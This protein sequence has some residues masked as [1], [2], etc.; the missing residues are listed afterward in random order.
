MDFAHCHCCGWTCFGIFVVLYAMITYCQRMPKKHFTKEKPTNVLITGGVQG[1][2]KLLAQKFAA[3]SPAGSVNLI[4]CD[5]REDLA[6]DLLEDVKK[7]SGDLKFANIHFYKANLA[8]QKDVEAFWAK[9]TSE[10]GEIHILVN[11][12]ARCIGKRVDE[13]SISQ[14]KLTMDINFHSYVHLMMLF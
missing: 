4:V 6:K 10:H 9:I 12:A 3:S 5:I 13:L 1:L 8:D 11:N 2:G 14:V 7:A